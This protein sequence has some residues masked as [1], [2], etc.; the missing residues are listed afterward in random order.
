MLSG[1]IGSQPRWDFRTAIAIQDPHWQGQLKLRCL[2]TELQITYTNIYVICFGTNSLIHECRRLCSGTRTFAQ[3]ECKAQCDCDWSCELIAG[4]F[5]FLALLVPIGGTRALPPEV[6]SSC[7]WWLHHL[8][9]VAAQ[10][11]TMAHSIGELLVG[12]A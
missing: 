6:G 7:W 11:R 4:L 10:H 8:A 9:C 3:F 1:T 5:L 12:A 2:K